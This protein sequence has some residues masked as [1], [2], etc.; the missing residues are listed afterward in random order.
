MMMKTVAN[1]SVVGSRGGVR[2]AALR[3]ATVSR[4][5]GTVMKANRA[6]AAI[7]TTCSTLLAATQAQAVELNQAYG[8]LAADNRA[9]VLL[10]V[11]APA[12]GWGLFLSV[13]GIS[14]QAQRTQRKSDEIARKQR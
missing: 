4:R 10:F 5:Q 3:P 8:D 7:A 6:A 9:G 13:Q 11:V 14:N 1:K 12:I 2:A